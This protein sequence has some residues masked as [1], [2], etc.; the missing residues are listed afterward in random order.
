ME[1]MKITN[2]EEV[3]V[4]E[5]CEYAE[6]VESGSGIFG[7]LVLGALAVAGG[8]AFVLHKTKDKREQRKIE[9][10]R[11]KGYVIREPETEVQDVD[12]V[13]VDETE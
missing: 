8:T 9:K 5:N 12:Y 7:K 4:E 2:I 13:S 11:K 6:P 1:D 3:E 10:L